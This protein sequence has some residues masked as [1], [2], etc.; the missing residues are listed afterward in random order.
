MGKI[1]I[2]YKNGCPQCSETVRLKR[3]LTQER[4]PFEEYDIETAEGLAE[5]AFYGVFSVPS[6]VIESKEENGIKKW[7]GSVPSFSEVIRA[8]KNL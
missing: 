4:I 3:Y 2:F 6:I 7:L 8:V 1:K 5:A